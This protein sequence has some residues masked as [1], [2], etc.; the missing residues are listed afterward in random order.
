MFSLLKNN[1]TVFL[2]KYPLNPSS[3]I[4]PAG[5][6]FLS[7]ITLLSFV[8]SVSAALGLGGGG[9][10]PIVVGPGATVNSW[11][12]DISPYHDPPSP[13]PPPT[14]PPLPPPPHPIL[15]F[16]FFM[17]LSSP[18]TIQDSTSATFFAKLFLI[19]SWGFQRGHSLG[20]F[21]H[22]AWTGKLK[23]SWKQLRVLISRFRWIYVYVQECC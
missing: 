22:E 1:I 11:V 10:G 2:W 12:G 9:G 13:H 17:R 18:H 8:P 20:F 21:L 4:L 7:N 6:P 15:T 5:L 16:L 14:P 3:T 23:L 19:F